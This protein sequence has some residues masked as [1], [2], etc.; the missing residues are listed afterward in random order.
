M[1]KPHTIKQ[2]RKRGGKAPHALDLNNSGH[3][4]LERKE[5]LVNICVIPVS[6][7]VPGRADGE[8]TIPSVSLHILY[9]IGVLV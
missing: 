7:G 1:T 6:G 4:Y 5:A 9:L 3:A 8:K 2:H